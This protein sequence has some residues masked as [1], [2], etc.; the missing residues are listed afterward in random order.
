MFCG[1]DKIFL[2]SPLLFFSLLGSSFILLF[3]LSPGS[4]VNFCVHPCLYKLLVC[5]ILEIFS[6]VFQGARSVL[7]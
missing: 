2:P 4:S 7:M 5:Y 6:G 3:S 1:I